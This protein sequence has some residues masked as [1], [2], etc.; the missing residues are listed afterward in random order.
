MPYYVHNKCLTGLVKLLNS[1]HGTIMMLCSLSMQMALW[2]YEVAVEVNRRL[3]ISS[4][5]VLRIHSI[6]TTNL[7]SG[8]FLEGQLG[9]VL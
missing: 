1:L 9:L 6:P 3:E 2:A 7:D 4:H 8:T 5:F